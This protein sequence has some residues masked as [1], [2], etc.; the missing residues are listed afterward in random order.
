MTRCWDQ[1]G[2]SPRS[3]RL[4]PCGVKIQDPTGVRQQQ[5]VITPHLTAGDPGYRCRVSVG[6][7]WDLLQRGLEKWDRAAYQLGSPVSVEKTRT[8]E[9]E[10]CASKETF[11]LMDILEEFRPR[12]IQEKKGLF[13]FLSMPLNTSLSFLSQ[14]SLPWHHFFSS[15][16]IGISHG[17]WH[18]S[19]TLGYR[20][21]C[22]PN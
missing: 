15:R 16:P 21:I 3:S 2:A 13:F 9:N 1:A 12:K 4:L 11:T 6:G 19:L 8:C 7:I 20:G 17:L 14:A 10:S 5:R 22:C 18:S